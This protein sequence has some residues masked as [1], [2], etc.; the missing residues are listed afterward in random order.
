MLKFRSAMFFGESVKS[1]HRRL[2]RRLHR[3]R[4]VK[5]G[6]TLITYAA[7]GQDLFDL[8]P[9]WELR[10]PYRKQQ[11]LY[12]LG[13]AGSKEEAV[14]LVKEMIMEVYGKTGGF[15]VRKYFGE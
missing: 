5:K 10:F 12:V 15:D 1:E 11:D 2:L 4:P 8:I 14:G 7:N 6:I 3:G 13:M 9:A